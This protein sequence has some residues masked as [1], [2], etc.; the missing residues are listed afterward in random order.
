MNKLI[1][2]IIKNVKQVAINID[3]GFILFKIISNCLDN[4][5]N[6]NEL[7]DTISNIHDKKK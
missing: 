5:R 7:K 3:N 1:D 4:L 6:K 2:F